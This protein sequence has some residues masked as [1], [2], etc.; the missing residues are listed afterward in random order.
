MALAVELQPDPAVD[1]PLALKAVGHPRFL[2]QADLPRSSTP[3]R[4][5]C[6]T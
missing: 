5:R 6:S 1:Q 3:A 4:I 2:E